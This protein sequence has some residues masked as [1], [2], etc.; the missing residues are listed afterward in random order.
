MGRI[1]TVGVTGGI[2]SGKT[3]VARI[4]GRLG[5][6]VY[7]AD[8]MAGALMESD[9]RLR[10]R[11]RA[12][13]GADTYDARGKLNRKRLADRVFGNPSL[14]RK[15]NAIVHPAVISV[16]KREMRR[17]RRAR[18]ARILVVEAALIF[19]AHTQSMFD[20]I[21]A[22]DAPERVRIDRLLRRGGIDTAGIR[23][24]MASQMPA[25]E[26][27]S[28]ADI[29]IRNAGTRRSLERRCRFV[30]DVLAG[31]ATLPHKT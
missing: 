7:V 13:F 12:S 4:F 29:V 22:V 10:R 28:R 27:V 6:K 21:V 15:L 1:L 26:K 14:I 2:G 23:R 18:T 30:F 25:R 16:L 20:Y 5:A 11:I 3:E 8:A 17:A 31:A 9:P 19:E 24:R